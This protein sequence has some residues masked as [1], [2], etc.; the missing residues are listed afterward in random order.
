M[1]KFTL[2][3]DALLFITA[4]FL[5]SVAGNVLVVLKAQ[6]I[7]QENTDVKAGNLLYQLT[8][9]SLQT[10]L[11]ECRAQLPEVTP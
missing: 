1:K 8:T 10:A 6:E 5:A 2:H 9:S 7:H 4:L 3:L 11:D